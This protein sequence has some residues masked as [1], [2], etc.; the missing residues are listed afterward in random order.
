M[1]QQNTSD[2]IESYIKKILEKNEMIELRRIELADLFNC[3]PS[4]INYVINT[5]FT[6]QRGYLVESKRGGGGYI[7][8]AKVRMSD[9]KQMLE[10]INLLFGET[11]NEKNAYAIIQKLYE[12]QIITKKEGN[13]ML[14]AIAKNTLN[15]NDTEDY[16]RARILRAFLERLSYEDGE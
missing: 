10:R 13:L 12:D 8:I 2:L 11:I 1:A 5:R 16:T 9:K 15:I 6:I 14:S 4:Q 3:V 7:R